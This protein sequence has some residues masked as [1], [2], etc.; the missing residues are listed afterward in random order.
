M[1]L[2]LLQRRIAQR[3]AK[4][5]RQSN[6]R[7]TK[8]D[9]PRQIT[10][11]GVFKFNF[12]REMKQHPG[13]S[14]ATF[15]LSAQH[16]GYPITKW[17]FRVLLLLSNQP[18]GMIFAFRSPFQ[19]NTPTAANSHLAG[20]L[21]KHWMA[22]MTLHTSSFCEPPLH[23]MRPKAKKGHFLMLRARLNFP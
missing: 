14:K 13:S 2:L 5:P 1:D 10:V 21:Q 22:Q 6:S 18:S 19:R 7:R 23:K 8:L 16:L 11:F 20:S 4:L 17:K 3:D 12:S 9:A 15:S